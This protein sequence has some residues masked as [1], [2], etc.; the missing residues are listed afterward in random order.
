M[1]IS[2][3]L[4][5]LIALPLA[6]LIALVIANRVQTTWLERETR[7]LAEDEIES[8]ATIGRF[9]RTFGARRISLRDCI[10]SEDPGECAKARDAF[11]MGKD[12]LDG[13]L[14]G[15][16]KK[17]IASEEDARYVREIGDLSSQWGAGAE[18]MLKTL[19]AGNRQQAAEMLIKDIGPLGSRIQS[20]ADEWTDLNVEV[21]SRAGAKLLA[22][23]ERVKEH[24]SEVVVAGASAKARELLHMTALDTLWALYNTR[25]EAMAALT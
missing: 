3:K 6:V 22:A 4:I 19:D 12:V 14:R 10:L 20:L 5:I 25:K 18:E 23:M 2:T 21:G 1:S 16:K 24:G 17:L 11:E 9:S 13:L 15:Y 8:L 7:L